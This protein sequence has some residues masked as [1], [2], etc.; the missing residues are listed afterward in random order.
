VSSPL[1]N[2]STHQER[3]PE[4]VDKRDDTSCGGQPIPIL[5]VSHLRPSWQR[6]DR[7]QLNHPSI[8]SLRMNASLHYLIESTKQEFILII[9]DWVD[10]NFIDYHYHQCNVMLISINPS[11][12]HPLSYESTRATIITKLHNKQA[13]AKNNSTPQQSNNQGKELGTYG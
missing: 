7:H 11:F 13:T 6:Y 10:Y 3:R 2:Q 4:R 8:N 9:Q 5:R 1:I 12:L